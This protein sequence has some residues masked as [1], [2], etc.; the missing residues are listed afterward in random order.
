MS[1]VYKYLFL[2]LISY[3]SPLILKDPQRKA[4]MQYDVLF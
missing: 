4:L 2:G 1:I 3:D